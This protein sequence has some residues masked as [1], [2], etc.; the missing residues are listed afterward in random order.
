MFKI[1]QFKTFSAGDKTVR[2]KII[3]HLDLR[4]WSQLSNDDKQNAYKHFWESWFDANVLQVIIYL[5]NEYL[6]IAP[7]K[8]LLEAKLYNHDF[9]SASRR[10]FT[11]I[12]LNGD[13]NLVLDMLSKFVEVSI[14]HSVLE[15]LEKNRERYDEECF[16]SKIDSAFQMADRHINSLNHIFEQFSVNWIFSR[17]GLFP[18]QDQR[19]TEEI[20]QPTLKILSDPKWK[21]VNGQLIKMFNAYRDKDYERIPTEASNSIYAFL[22]VITGV[23]VNSKGSFGTLFKEV[24]SSINKTDSVKRFLDNLGS[25]ISDSR[26][27]DGSAKPDI[28]N[29]VLLSPSESLLIMNE[30]MILLQYLLT[31]QKK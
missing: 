29:K 6:R 31:S 5:N 13:Q 16:N 14:D 26:A 24:L 18:R 2:E 4:E 15:N 20:Y 19:I 17:E 12:F 30:V 10:D 28:K 9:F 3:P 22:K 27:N 23:E 25:F 1:P 11:E 8:N 21:N 7:G